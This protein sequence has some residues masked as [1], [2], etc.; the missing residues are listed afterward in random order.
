MANIR[1]NKLTLVFILILILVS[2]KS[3]L[4]T[5]GLLDESI[6][7]IDTSNMYRRV[8][9]TN[10]YAFDIKEELELYISQTDDTILNT[11]KRYEMG[12]LDKNESKFYTL[13]IEREKGSK[14]NKGVIEFYSPADSIPISKMKKREVVFLFEQ[15]KNDTLYF[16][17]II[18]NSSRIEFDFEYYQDLKFV[19][20]ISDIRFFEMNENDEKW[21]VNRNFFALDSEINTKNPFVEL[22]N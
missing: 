13:K 14:K 16:E 20:Y 9:I 12:V 3:D 19:G 6:K 15:M 8:Q 2:C 22:L 11:I 1:M 10:E 17:E 18:T 5:S 4:S 21:L 7:P